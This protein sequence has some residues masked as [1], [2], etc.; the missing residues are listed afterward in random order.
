MRDSDPAYRKIAHLEVAHLAVAHLAVA[1]RASRYQAV[2]VQLRIG[3]KSRLLNGLLAGMGAR[4]AVLITASNPRGRRA[5]AAWNARMM[6]RLHAALARRTAYPAESGSGI[7][8]EQQFMVAGPEAWMKRL[9][10]HYRQVA[11]VRLRVG[12]AP[13]LLLL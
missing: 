6:A 12:Q 7:W 8:R 1:Y 9:G 2:G 3:R 13:R 5:P 4:A 10:R 11:L